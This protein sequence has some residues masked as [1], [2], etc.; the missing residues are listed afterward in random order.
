MLSSYEYHIRKDMIAF[1]PYFLKSY[2][3]RNFKK[4]SGSNYCEF[5]NLSEASH[6]P[7][8]LV[9]RVASKDKQRIGESEKVSIFHYPW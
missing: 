7:I 9:R 4:I 5:D 8:K 1:F 2:A 6:E 3:N